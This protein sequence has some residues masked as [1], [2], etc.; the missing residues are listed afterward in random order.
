L[1]RVLP[2]LNDEGLRIIKDTVEQ[3][4][5]NLDDLSR[6]TKLIDWTADQFGD[7]ANLDV[8]EIGAGIGTY[9]EVLLKRGVRSV[10]AM[11]PDPKCFE[12]LKLRFGD[13]ERVELSSDGIPGGEA[14]RSSD[15]G[16]LVLCQNV[17]EHIGDDRAAFL[18]MVSSI[19][20]G[21]RLF[22]LVPANPWL[23]GSLD[24]T[25]EH[26]RRYRKA[27]LEILARGA[28]LTDVSIR[29]FNGLGIPGWWLKGKTGRN[30]IGV[31]SLRMYEALLGAWRPIEDRFGSPIGLSL[32]L[33]ARKGE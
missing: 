9:T 19:R 13:D 33:T 20:P 15:G 18:E 24:A 14:L 32:I 8:I 7:I 17:L 28:D 6:A 11:E 16:D 3:V 27:D 31:R 4:E 23:Y 26:F 12:S 30:E 5:W 25:F 10:L 1:R 29:P 2:L 21:G 22:L